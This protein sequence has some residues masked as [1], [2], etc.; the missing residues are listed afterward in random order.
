MPGFSAVIRLARDLPVVRSFV[1]F[2]TGYNRLFPTLK[3]AEAFIADYD[4]GGHSHPFCAINLMQT[5]EKASPSDYAALFFIQPLVPVIRNIF[6]FGG[7]VGNLFYCYAKYVN[8]PKDFIWTV[9]DVAENVELGE[10][11][12]GDFGESRLR[13]TTSLSDGDGVD[14]FMA[15]GALHYFEKPLPDILAEFRTKPRFV[16]I[17]R[18]PLTDGQPFA[19]VQDAGRYR[20]AC[21]LHNHDDL[22][23]RFE[24]AGY[25]LVDSWRAAERSLIIPCYPDRSVSAYSGMFFRLRELNGI[26]N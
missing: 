17:N 25:E 10:R 12:A 11:I 23:R 7:S 15:T 9:Y 20:V 18:T 4:G 6:D 26:S 5:I 16:L 14:L 21:I 8:F 13:F 3:E 2:L 1:K 24:A 22:V 19:T